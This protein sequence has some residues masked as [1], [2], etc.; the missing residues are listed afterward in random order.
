MGNVS[1]YSGGQRQ[2][3]YLVSS[4]QIIKSSGLGFAFT[5]GHGI[6]DITTYYDD[7]DRLDCVDWE[8]MQSRYWNDTRDDPDRKRR[9]QAEFLVYD[10]L[11]WSLVSEVGVYDDEARAL[12]L[13]AFRNEPHCPL[14]KIRPD[15]YY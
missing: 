9:R 15:W 2:V 3:V 12:V 4:A 6:I 8:L 14:A 7:L 13:D 5:D 11:P 1:Q 10:S